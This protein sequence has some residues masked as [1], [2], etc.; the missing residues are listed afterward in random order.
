MSENTREWYDRGK[1]AARLGLKREL[2]KAR[3]EG[4][5]QAR[6][7]AAKLVQDYPDGYLIAAAIRAMEYE[8]EQGE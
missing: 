1:A 7:L 2:A 3:R 4:F 5:E 8:E 6:E